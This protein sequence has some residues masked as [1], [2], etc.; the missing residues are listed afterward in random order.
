MCQSRRRVV[1][2]VLLCAAVVDRS[3]AQ[4]GPD[5]D[6]GDDCWMGACDE[7]TACPRGQFCNFDAG[8]SGQCERCL[9][10]GVPDDG[11]VGCLT[12]DLNP[13]GC[14]LTP[15][16]SADCSARCTANAITTLG[17]YQGVGAREFTLV[18]SATLDDTDA[19]APLLSLTDL[20]TGETGLAYYELTT[21]AR[22]PLTLRYEMFTGDGSG[23]DGQCV[24][25]GANDLGGRNGEDGVADG[26]AL[27]FDEY[28][29]GGDRELCSSTALRALLLT[30]VRRLSATLS[31]HYLVVS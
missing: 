4:V 7:T 1:A 2:I 5:P 14:G 23:A 30:S 6:C 28:S 24:N 22:D 8:T 16:G 29:N 20:G 17:D 10:C 27:C 15:A 3:Q 12:D 21:G 13:D 25:I 9:A 18:G 31:Y 11:W 26:L 19:A